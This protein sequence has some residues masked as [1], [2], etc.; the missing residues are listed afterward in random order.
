MRLLM[1]AHSTQG[2]VFNGIPKYIHSNVMLDP[3][4]KLN[5]GNNVV[6]ST[7]VTILTHDYSYTVGLLATNQIPTTDVA[8]FKPVNIGNNTFIGANSVILPGSNIGDY[9]VIGAG[10]VIKGNVENYS[11][12]LGNPAHK[13][14]DTRIWGKD[15]L[16]KFNQNEIHYDNK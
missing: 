9:C 7:N 16:K 5:I 1:K 10:C 13:I 15:I 8:I 14:G 11:I 3:L 4:G 6:I 12:M 2:V